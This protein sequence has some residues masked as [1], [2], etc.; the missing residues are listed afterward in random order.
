MTRIILL[1]IAALATLT[2]LTF[3]LAGIS[4]TYP[5]LAAITALLAVA[6]LDRLQRNRWRAGRA[7]VWERRDREAQPWT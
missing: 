5:A 4:F 3:A 2:A 7:A 6:H 1:T